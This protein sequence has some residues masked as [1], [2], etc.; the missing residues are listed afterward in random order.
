MQNAKAYRRH[1]NNVSSEE[2]FGFSG[3]R[4]AWQ[5]EVTRHGRV[6]RDGRTAWVSSVPIY[7]PSPKSCALHK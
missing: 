1:G 7:A 5:A 2:A 6:Q 3:M 4:R